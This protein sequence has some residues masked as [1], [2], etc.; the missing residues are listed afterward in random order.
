MLHALRTR[1]LARRGLP[2]LE[3]IDADEFVGSFDNVCVMFA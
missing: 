2:Q 1:N 3:V